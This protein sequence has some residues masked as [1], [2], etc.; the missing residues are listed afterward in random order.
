MTQ[1]GKLD[2]AQLSDPG[3]VVIAKNVLTLVGG[4]CVVLEDREKE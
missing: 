2:I 4:I 3:V 1:L